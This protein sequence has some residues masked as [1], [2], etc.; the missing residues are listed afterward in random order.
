MLAFSAIMG[1][2]NSSIYQPQV[3]LFGTNTR[4]KAWAV[5]NALTKT[6]TFVIIHKDIGEPFSVAISSPSSSD[7]ITAQVLEL[8]SSKLTDLNG[9]TLGGVSFPNPNI[10]EYKEHTIKAS[11]SL[12]TLT[13]KTGTATIVRIGS[14][15]NAL[16]ILVL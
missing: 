3:N 5:Y 11:N 7:G 9:F 14:A 13:C 12:F 6:H 10:T 1:G 2:S 8:T 15:A 4:L 16:P